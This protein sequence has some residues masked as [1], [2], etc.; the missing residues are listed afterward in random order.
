M[1]L[2]SLAGKRDSHMAWK[3]WVETGVVPLFSEKDEDG[4]VLV[5][6]EGLVEIQVLGPV[7][8]ILIL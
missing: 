7:P 8:Q 2:F 3:G 1:D 6:K 4:L 5:L